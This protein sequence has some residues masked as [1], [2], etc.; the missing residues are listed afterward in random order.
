MKLKASMLSEV[1]QTRK[2][3][4]LMFF[5]IFGIWILKKINKGRL[6]SIQKGE[7]DQ[8]ERKGGRTK[9]LGRGECDNAS[10]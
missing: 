3:K 4:Y 8:R 5:P 2:C 7:G 10:L 1:K 9:Y 6:D